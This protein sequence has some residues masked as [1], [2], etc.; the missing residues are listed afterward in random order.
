MDSPYPSH[1]SERTLL[2]LGYDMRKVHNYLVIDGDNLTGEDPHLL[3]RYN[4]NL[5][6]LC[7]QEVQAFDVAPLGAAFCSACYNVLLQRANLA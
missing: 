4:Q 1:Y 7:N 6:T 5:T 3:D 2:H